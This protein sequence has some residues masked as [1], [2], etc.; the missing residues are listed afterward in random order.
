MAQLDNFQLYLD[1][2][3]T[4]NP[5][6]DAGA[7]FSCS[8]TVHLFSIS[9]PSDFLK[10]V[11]DSFN[12]IPLNLPLSYPVGSSANLYEE[13]SSHHPLASLMIYEVKLLLMFSTVASI[14]I[15]G[16]SCI[17][18]L[19]AKHDVDKRYQTKAAKERVAGI[20]FPLVLMVRKDKCSYAVFSHLPNQPQRSSTTISY[21]IMI[22]LSIFMTWKA[23][24]HAYY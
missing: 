24:H 8:N 3:T 5:D 17:T 6:S 13:I 7:N 15:K 4:E 9:H 20:Y 23:Q 11:T 19:I 12:Y 1:N 22:D 2:M 18:N 16:F 10:I 21:H 14:R